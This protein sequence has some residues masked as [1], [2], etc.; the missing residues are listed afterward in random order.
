[1][2]LKARV[3]Q[4]GAWRG[5]S[6]DRSGEKGRCAEALCIYLRNPPSIV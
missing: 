2:A 5:V 1:M 4:V 3:R 6:E